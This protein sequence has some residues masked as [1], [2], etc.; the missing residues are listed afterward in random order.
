MLPF[1]R[2]GPLHSVLENDENSFFIK[3]RFAFGG[4]V[5]SNEKRLQSVC[6]KQLTTIYGF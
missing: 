6:G 1:T 2:H 3:M 5:A 4:S